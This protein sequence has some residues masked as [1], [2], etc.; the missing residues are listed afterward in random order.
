[1]LAMNKNVLILKW[2]AIAMFICNVIGWLFFL[3]SMRDEHFAPLHSPRDQVIEV[4]HFDQK[5]I[6]QY[7]SIIRLHQNNLKHSLTDIESAKANLY[8]HLNDSTKQ[9]SDSI[10]SELQRATIAL[11]KIHFDHFLAIRAICRKEQLAS[12]QSLSIS[13]PQF[14]RPPAPP[15]P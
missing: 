10:W 7:D 9:Q 13:F 11:E 8:V 3:R 14:F 4:L 12:F 1:M 15:R 5:Q 2:I 6:Q